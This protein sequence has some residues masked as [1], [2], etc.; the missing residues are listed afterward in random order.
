MTEDNNNHAAT[1]P[2][3][4]WGSSDDWRA[5][6]YERDCLRA[7]LARVRQACLFSED[8]GRIGITTDPCIDEQLFN[9]IQAAI[10][11]ARE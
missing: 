6:A 3:G 8:D 11:K 10:A 7:I 2:L 4:P 1:P 9:D 5:I